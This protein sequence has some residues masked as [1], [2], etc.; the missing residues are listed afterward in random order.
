MSEN[1]ATRAEHNLQT[2][3][4]GR[5]SLPTIPQAHSAIFP[6][7]PRL[8]SELSLLFPTHYTHHAV[9][10]SRFRSTGALPRPLCKAH[11]QRQQGTLLV[12]HYSGAMLGHPL[13]PFPSPPLPSLLP[14]PL[15][16]PGPTVSLSLAP[17]TGPKTVPVLDSVKDRVLR[18]FCEH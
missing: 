17:Q 7:K 13:L 3:L 1:A 9:A 15:S 4:I 18:S 11:V 2:F 8:V 16:A 14:I 6:R 10:G 5:P 12:V